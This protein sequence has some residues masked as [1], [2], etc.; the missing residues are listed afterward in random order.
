MDSI[1]VKI[2]IARPLDRLFT[3]SIPSEKRDLVVLG[4]WV[5]VS[6]G[7]S[8]TYGFIQEVMGNLSQI[9][10]DFP[11]TQLKSVIDVGPLDQALPEKI[12]ALC[13]WTSKYY[14]T[15][16]GEVCQTAS[17]L[18]TLGLKTAVKEA[19]GLKTKDAVIQVVKDLTEEQSE[20]VKFIL[21]KMGAEKSPVVLLKGVTGSGKTE[22]Y[23]EVAREVL[24]SGKGVLFL[25][26]EI[27]LTSQLVRRIEEGLGE[28]VVEWHSAMS[29]GK[30]RDQTA[31]LRK[32]VLRVVVGARSGVFS[33]V[34]NLGLIVVDEE[35]DPTYKQEDRVRYHARDLAIVR[36]KMEDAAVILGSAT[37]SLESVHRCD[38]GKYH[39]SEL[40]SRFSKQG[41]PNIELVSLKDELCVEGIQARLAE[42]TLTEI[43]ETISRGDQVMLFLN[44]RGFAQFLLCEDCGE[45]EECPNCSISLTYHFQKKQLKCHVCGFEEKVP[46]ACQ[47]CGSM[48][49]E[50][51][52]AGTESLEEEIPKL[53]PDARIL[54]LDRDTV[55][56][57]TRLEAILDDFRY[58]IG[59]AHV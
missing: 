26:P 3:Y 32:G 25:V 16:L 1:V 21:E 24:R 5:K 11:K 28:R 53:L 41:M 56:S 18:S 42:R 14:C 29:P 8:T 33:P 46:D 13:Q 43:R 39:F 9:E 51:M 45:V 38:Q 12:L 50:M 27:A 17:P 6:F 2:A 55:T 34:P 15:A 22:V 7:R 10:L 57:A 20:S 30:R 48:N 19:K 54:R 47:K 49:Q 58:K 35:H 59:R 31:A 37:P 4:A 52:G 36:A 44:R 40:K 23:F